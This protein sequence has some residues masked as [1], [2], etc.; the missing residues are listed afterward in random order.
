MT[1]K[2]AI[3]D[4]KTRGWL[5]EFE[6]DP[7]LHK[8]FPVTLINGTSVPGIHIVCSNCSG[9]ISGDRIRGRVIKSLPHVLTVSA[10]GYCEKCDRLTHVDCRFRSS[11]DGT[12]IEWLAANGCWQA[13]ELRQPTLAEKIARGARRLAAWIA[14]AL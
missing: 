2:K 8:I 13:R 11:A 3:S 9:S 1:D 7:P 10:N 4:A 6:S 12:L 14:A 5:A